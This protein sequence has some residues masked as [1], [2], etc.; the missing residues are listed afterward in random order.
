MATE[1]CITEDCDM[2][3]GPDALE[4]T[5]KGTPAGYICEKCLAETPAV[6]ILFRKKE[7]LFQ[8]TDVTFLEKPLDK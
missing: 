5:H 8:A 7:G 3:C 6:R 4:F 1:H 2:G